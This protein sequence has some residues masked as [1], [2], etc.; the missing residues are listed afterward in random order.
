LK[1]FLDRVPQKAK[2][3]VDVLMV[4][5]GGISENQKIKIPKNKT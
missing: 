1:T 3:Y 2:I 5:R 4:G